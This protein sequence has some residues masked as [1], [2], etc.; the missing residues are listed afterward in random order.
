MDLGK[1]KEV[2]ADT[3]RLGMLVHGFFLFGF[4]TET[5]EDLETT[6]RYAC[7]SRLDLA[8]FNIVNAFPGTELAKFAQEKGLQVDFSLDDYDYDSPQFQLSEVSLDELKTIIRKAHS[9]FYL[10]PRRL[11]R[12]F[13][14][15]PRKR[16]ILGLA[17]YFVSKIYLWIKE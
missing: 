13:W 6:I 17:R 12:I 4:P 5:Q 2:I 1:L 15:L 8:S 11:L 3:S 7:S 14:L 10:S 16:Q 9:R